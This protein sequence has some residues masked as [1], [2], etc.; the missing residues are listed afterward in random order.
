MKNNN[1]QPHSAKLLLDDFSSK[2]IDVWKT[3]DFLRAK[4]GVDG[5]EWPEWCFMPNSTYVHIIKSYNFDLTT[6][7]EIENGLMLSV[8]SKW[9]VGQGVYRFDPTLYDSLIK[10][11]LDGDIPS[12]ILL[13]IPQWCLYIET[14][15]HKLDTHEIRGCFVHL[16]YNV[17]S[18]TT[19][20]HFMFD[21]DDL[22]QGKFSF[23]KLGRWSLQD[24]I[25]K[26]IDYESHGTPELLVNQ[27]KEVRKHRDFILK[28][29]SDVLRPIISLLLYICSINAEY[30]GKE[31]PFNTPAIKTKKGIRTFPPNQVKTWEIGTRI[32]A[33]IRKA[34]EKSQNVI[35]DLSQKGT[36]S[37]PKPHV[38]RAHWHGF[39]SGPKDGD[40]HLKIKWLPPIPVNISEF[41]NLPSVI[42]P[43]Q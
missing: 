19:E 31:S 36:N 20:L 27:I 6:I 34:V 38:R 42:H 3:V 30:N 41:E 2:Y 18:K 15:G 29:Q 11:N 33:A 17:H 28:S 12:E 9:R 35:C 7:Q 24:S 26:A 8:F 10:T 16:E 32:G 25:N 23:I 14:P 1:L 39:W 4:K 5:F 22:N 43:V 40:R 21:A 37:S 13:K